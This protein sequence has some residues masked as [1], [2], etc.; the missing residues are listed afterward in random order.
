[1]YFL[2]FVLFYCCIFLLIEADRIDQQCRFNTVLCF[3]Y[4]NLNLEFVQKHH[5]DFT[6]LPLIFILWHFDWCLD[7]P[8]VC[9]KLKVFVLYRLADEQEPWPETTAH[10]PNESLN[11]SAIYCLSLWL[12]VSSLSNTSS[13]HQCGSSS[14]KLTSV[15]FFHLLFH[16]HVV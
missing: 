3:R 6:D 1:M 14:F 2:L 12:K 8:P 5:L 13:L 15:W 4:W 9:V 11:Q 7:C 10:M 16:V